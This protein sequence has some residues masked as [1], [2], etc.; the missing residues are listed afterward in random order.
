MILL[1][2]LSFP[3]SG[4]SQDRTRAAKPETLTLDPDFP[5]GYQVE[6]ADLDG[7]GRPDVVGLG[8][9]TCAW[10]ENPGW[11]KRI[12]TGPDRTPGIIS[13]SVWKPAGQ[14]ALVAIA[15]DFEMNAPR[16]GKLL[17][18]KVAA[19]LDSAPEL[20]ELGAFPSIH[21]IRWGDVDGDQRPE[22]VVAPIFGAAAMPPDFQQSRAEVLVL[23][24]DPNTLRCDGP[25]L[26]AGADHVMHAIR[27]LDFDA[28]GRDEILCAGNAGITLLDQTPNGGW[29]AR[30]LVPGFQGQPPARGCSE[31]HVG[32]LRQAASQN[33]IPFLA[34]IEPWH[35]NQVVVYP[36]R[37]QV[38]G[39]GSPRSEPE[40][41]RVV[42][43]ESLDLG[44]ALC[45]AD[46]DGDGDDEV[47]AGHRG[48]DARVSMYD[49]DG[50][51]LQWVKTVIDPGF[52]AQD[53]R[54]G[55]LD[56]DGRPEVVAIA[57]DPGAIH[58]YRWPA[59]R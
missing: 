10:Y 52:R 5:S 21:R 34:T 18:A 23:R 39:P 4:W 53:L 13:S 30:V 12:I 37:V 6:I 55:D 11:K 16:R 45:V 44:H 22:L 14:P 42:L 43:D 32:R 51:Q 29:S 36:S 15:Y 40:P 25:I 26:A 50:M 28:D 59:G 31:I 49:F 35:G 8:G 7:D 24:V 41:R 17:V 54:S 57:G 46:V 20:V 56:G 2:G 48:K 9:G 19:E 47:F 58:L 38:A 33:A 27:V 1:L 3:G